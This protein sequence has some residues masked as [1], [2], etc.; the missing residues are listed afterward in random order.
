MVKGNAY[1]FTSDLGLFV[2]NLQKNVCEGKIRVA[3][4]AS[5]VFGHYL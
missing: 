1:Q 4:E 2:S 3:A 5:C